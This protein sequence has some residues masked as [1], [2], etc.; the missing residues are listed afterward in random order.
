MQQHLIF[1]NLTR[2]KST[3]IFL[4]ICSTAC[5]SQPFIDLA[6]ISYAYTPAKG[7]GEKTDPITCHYYS[8][9]ITLPLEIKK[10]GDA[11]IVNPFIEHYKGEMNSGSFHVSSAGA[12]LAFLKKSSSKKWSLLSTL[13]I[14][15]NKATQ[16]K[17]DDSWQYGGALITTW[18]KKASLSLKF[19]LYYN[20]E[21]FGNF[22]VPLAGI[23]WRINE[24]NNLFGVLPGNLTYEHQFSKNIWS[25]F[26]FR[27]ITNSYRLP[28]ADP[29]FSGDCT[30]K[31]YL[32]INDN[33]LGVYTDMQLFSK[34]IL[35][36]ETGYSIL[37]NYRFG[38]RG[39]HS[40]QKSDHK[41]DNFYL[42]AMMAY[43]LRL[44]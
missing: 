7:I 13:I 12:A 44:R 42:R 37:R 16:K 29:C 17:A 8:A 27:S 39:D 43:R 32:R 2:M 1:L 19:G 40:D 3:F 36:I 4:L 11:V 35:N 18:Q 6:K 30:G 10:G 26:V 34:L 21:F 41:S 15:Q 20:K 5:S 33:Q 24:K 28:V 31:N 38:F 22:F 23:D 9:N 25:G 14:R